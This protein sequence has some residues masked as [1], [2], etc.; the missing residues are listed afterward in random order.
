MNII[1]VYILK[2]QK[3]IFVIQFEESGLGRDL[4][5]FPYNSAVQVPA[6]ANPVH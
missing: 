3:F 6:Y 4:A 5:G 1:L 2:R